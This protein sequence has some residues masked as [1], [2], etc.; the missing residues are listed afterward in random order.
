MLGDAH[1]AAA[2]AGVAPEPEPADIAADAGWCAQ[3]EA[4]LE[5]VGLPAALRPALAAKLRLGVFDAG[6]ALSFGWD[7]GVGWS[8]RAA[9][10]LAAGADVWLCDHVW[11]FPT[12]AAGPG[13]GGAFARGP[14][15]A[16]PS[17]S[18]LPQ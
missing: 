5:A 6:A 3:H 7:D 17:E 10:D 2:A 15:R 8:V 18:A 13:R 14:S 11:L 16:S 12:A 9:V 4:Q 1:M